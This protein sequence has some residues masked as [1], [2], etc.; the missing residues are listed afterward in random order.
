LRRFPA[1]VGHECP[2]HTSFHIE[3]SRIGDPTQAAGGDSG[4]AES[5][6]VALAKFVLAVAQQ[7]LEG[8]IDVAEAEEAEV[9]DANGRPLSQMRIP[10]PEGALKDSLFRHA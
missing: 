4:D 7:L 10:A 5:N 1:F 9:V 3:A 8:A 2:T 6:S